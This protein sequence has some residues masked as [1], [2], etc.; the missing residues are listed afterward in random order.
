MSKYI[1]DNVSISSEE[2]SS[3][4]ENFHEESYSEL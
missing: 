1:T 4:K 2:E 3:D